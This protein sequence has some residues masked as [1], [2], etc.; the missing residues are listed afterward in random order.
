MNHYKIEGNISFYDELFKSLD[1][2]S[3]DGEA[4]VC[5]IS[6]LPLED[7]F[8][9][10]ECNHK[11]N[12]NTIYKELC[13]Q[14]FDFKTYE[15]HHLTRKEQLKVKNSN[16]DYFIKCPYCRNIQ[17]SILPEYEELGLEKKYGINSLDETLPS[18]TINCNPNK[19][20]YGHDDYT[21]IMFGVTFTKAPCCQEILCQTIPKP[22]YKKCLYIYSALIPNTNIYY[23]KY[24]YKKG[25][26]D[27]NKKQYLKSIE[28][29]KK[30]KENLLKEKQNK[31]EEINKI[32]IEKGLAPLKR[33]VIKK[34]S[35]NI[36][37]AVLEITKFN[38]DQ[39][40]QNIDGN[41]KIIGCKA[42]LKTGSNKGKSCG[43]KIINE[44]N[45]CKRHN[46]N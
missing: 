28:E 22:I 31:L 15:N 29:K 36:V 10:L 35:E 34:K 3:D 7:K 23:C 41:V 27:Y 30:Q 26:K 46:K 43:C 13:R 5:L 33:L 37:E 32:R 17:F 11:F 24:H 44:N 9:T 16:L 1:D 18:R 14:K 4:L 20:Y 2:E 8:V 42:I 12:Y 6:G 39:L 19:V 25:F 38:P 21:F 40:N 45:L